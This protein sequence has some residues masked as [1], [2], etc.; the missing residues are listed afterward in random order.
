LAGDLKQESHEEITAHM[1]PV[2]YKCCMKQQIRREEKT[3]QIALKSVF[4]NYML[5]LQIKCKYP[6]GAANLGD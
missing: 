4:T 1:I 3:G 2:T 6:E 5:S